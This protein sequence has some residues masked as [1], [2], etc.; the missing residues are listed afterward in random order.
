MSNLEKNIICA[1]DGDLMAYLYNEMPSD[2]RTQFEGH[3][4][5]CESCIDAFAELA[6][7]RYSVYEWQQIEFVPLETP[8][9][10]I[11]YAPATSRSSWITSLKEAFTLRPQ[12][13]FARAFGALLVTMVIGYVMLSSGS[14]TIDVATGSK[15]EEPASAAVVTEIETAVSS[16]LALSDELKT[17]TF[18][19]ED[20]EPQSIPVRQPESASRSVRETRPA[21][22]VRVQPA[23]RV[24]P[25]NA[26]QTAPRL[27]DFADVADDSL[28]LA[29]LFDDI[30]TSE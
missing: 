3:L 1:N 30:E 9:F 2:S 17:E 14:D 8:V 23:E 7:S 19:V 10:E 13:A 24:T 12:M 26:T 29:D 6:D 21:Q 20:Q 11:P 16:D 4:A 22:R 5:E 18:A 25:V 15:V 28:R 27:N